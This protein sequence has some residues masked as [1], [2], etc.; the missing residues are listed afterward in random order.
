MNL[1]PKIPIGVCLVA[2]LFLLEGFSSITGMVIS[3]FR[4]NFTFDLFGLISVYAGL[5]LLRLSNGWRIYALIVV[6]LQLAVAVLLFFLMGGHSWKEQWTVLS[7]YPIWVSR[8]Q[9][10]ALALL[11]LLTSVLQ[12]IILLKP[13]IR[14]YFRF[15]PTT[16]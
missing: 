1:N 2:W 3:L 5:G 9:R 7:C 4:S 12:L 6:A 11:F 8:T 15:K 10:I 14:S 13:S 16:A